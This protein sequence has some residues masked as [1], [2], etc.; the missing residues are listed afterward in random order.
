[1]NGIRETFRRCA[2]TW[3]NVHG[4][5]FFQRL[6][7]RFRAEFLQ[8]RSLA[9]RLEDDI[10][11][12]LLDTGRSQLLLTIPESRDALVLAGDA[13]KIDRTLPGTDRLAKAL[14][15]LEL[16]SLLLDTRLTREQIVHAFLLVLYTGAGFAPV[17]GRTTAS[18]RVRTLADEML[19]D[20]GLHRFSTLIHAQPDMHLLEI[21][22]Q[23][24]EMLSTRLI[25]A[26]LRLGR[27]KDH[28]V[29]AKAAPFLGITAAI[30]AVIDLQLWVFHPT[31]ALWVSLAIAAVLGGLVAN[32][33]YAISS[34]QYDREHRDSLLKDSLREITDLSHF[35]LQ[36]PNPNLKCSAEG[37]LLY[38]N[39]AAEA[40]LQK[41]HLPATAV[42]DILPDDYL[43]RIRTALESDSVSQDVEVQKHE[44]TLLWRFGR[45]PKERAVLITGVDVTPL[46]TLELELRDMNET[47][48]QRVQARTFELMLTQDVTI[49]SLSTL[50]ESR[51][52]DTGAHLERTRNYVRVLAEALKEHPKFREFLSPPGVIDQLYR[53]APLHDIGKVGTRDAILLKNGRLDEN[54]FEVM[55]Q[56]AILGGDTLRWAEARLGTNSFLQFAREIAY[57]HH[58]KWDGSGYPFGMKGEE[59]PI[60]ARLMAV[61]DVY[62]ALRSERCYK[63][64]MSHKEARS[65]ITEGTGSQFDP[66]V[67]DA[68]LRCEDQFITIADHY[69]EG[70]KD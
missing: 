48:E 51:D 45:F 3:R 4:Y 37:L 42:Q 40:L 34:M 22:Y 57:Y 7:F 58:E 25:D 69:A 11:S 43:Q 41:L 47:L 27:S 16:R 49:M 13:G 18:R 2:R 32:L 21:E 15:N 61:A 6:R 8:F 29:L 65:L 19:S 28:R 67:V 70:K 56:H 46:K 66:D 23:Y 39:P 59:I 38:A 35:P 50:A 10:F 60:S 9:N 24:T 55:K 63:N 44:K 12:E 30:L 64:A 36:S 54:E 31:L 33:M 53:S 1:M 26:W 62:D 52:P 14:S 5:L 17:V 68:F 20:A